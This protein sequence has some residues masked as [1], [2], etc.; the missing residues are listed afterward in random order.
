MRRY[1]LNGGTGA[2]AALSHSSTR[3]ATRAIYL[4]IGEPAIGNMKQ[5]PQLI[6]LPGAL[7]CSDDMH[8]SAD[9]PAWVVLMQKTRQCPPMSPTCIHPVPREAIPLLVSVLPGTAPQ[10]Q[11]HGERLEHLRTAEPVVVVGQRG[12]QQGD[13]RLGKLAALGGGTGGT[14]GHRHALACR[15]GPG[16]G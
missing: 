14:E 4:C 2:R 1:I 3:N 7:M 9:H 15:G 11:Q 10:S 16:Q 6:V 8:R 13:V 12:E 5:A